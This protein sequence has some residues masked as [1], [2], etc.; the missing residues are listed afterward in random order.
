MAVS[1]CF[2]FLAQIPG[3]EEED[4]AGPASS[5]EEEL[6]KRFKDVMR[7]IFWDRFTQSLL[8]PPDT[9][10][11]IDK[12]AAGTGDAGSSGAVVA[13]GSNCAEQKADVMAEVPGLP[14]LRVGSKVHARYGS[15]RGSYYVATVL[16]VVVKN[17]AKNEKDE[18]ASQQSQSQPQSR[19]SGPE[20]GALS[21]AA[22]AAGAGAAAG[23]GGDGV[24]VD[25]RYDEDGMVERGVPVSRLK[26]RDDPPDFGPLL[27]LLGEVPNI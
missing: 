4:G 19:G 15:E 24:L 13:G 9:S 25:V 10:S 3:N 5:P 21:G 26:K 23:E 20:S 14:T 1:L 27:S 8:P 12:T 2:P 18:Q 22:A 7:R 6:A 11:A 16:A 17:E